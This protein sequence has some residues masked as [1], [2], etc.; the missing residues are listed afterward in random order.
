MYSLA[1]LVDGKEKAEPVLVTFERG[2]RQYLTVIELGPESEDEQPKL[3]K[4][5]WMGVSTQVLTRELAKALGLGRKKGVRV[6]QV[7]PG[8]QAEKAGVQPGDLLLKL[9]GSVIQASRREDGE[10]FDNLIRQYPADSEVELSGLRNGEELKLKV[11]LQARPMP[12]SQLVNY[13]DE[14]FEFSVR[15]LAFQDRVAKD[16]ES[17]EQGLL[18][19]QVEAAGWGALAGLRNG[20]LLLEIDGEAV[21]IIKV[22]MVFQPLIVSVQA[23]RSRVTGWQIGIHGQRVAAEGI[24][25]GIELGELTARVCFLVDAIDDTAATAA[26]KQKG[27]GTTKYFNLFDVIERPII[28]NIVANPFDEEVRGGLDA[29]DDDRVPMAFALADRQARCVAKH[30]TKVAEGLI[31]NLLFCENCQALRNIQD[32]CGC[33]DRVHLVD[34]QVRTL[35]DNLFN[36]TVRLIRMNQGTEQQCT[37]CQAELGVFFND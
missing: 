37:G 12:S 7:Y 9:D 25:A 26:S 34:R 35:N 18:I 31:L 22:A 11:P 2:N 16:L 30:I 23:K 8:T 29:T 21:T 33:F 20:D 19:S 32:R 5:A 17:S 28:L 24:N 3:A 4:K 14:N 1:S 15:E 13:E 10:V 36:G 6:T 27:V